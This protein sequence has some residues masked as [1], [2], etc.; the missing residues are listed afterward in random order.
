MDNS[1][2][3]YVSVDNFAVSAARVSHP[4]WDRSP[5]VIV[6]SVHPYGVVHSASGQAIREGVRKGMSLRRA[7]QKCARARFVNL[8]EIN[9]EQFM[10]PIFHLLSQLSP[11]TQRVSADE[12]F[13]DLDGCERLHGTWSAH[14]LGFLPFANPTAGTYIRDGNRPSPPHKRTLPPRN[15]RWI[16]AIGAWLRRTI[17]HRIGLPVSIGCASNTLAAQCASRFISSRGLVWIQPGA[18]A[19]FFQLLSLKD[20]PGIGSSIASKL[21]KWNIQTVNAAQRLSPHILRTTFGPKRGIKIHRL[22]HGQ[23]PHNGGSSDTPRKIS[24]ERTFWEPSN[25]YQFVE[26]VLHYLVELV[27]NRLRHQGLSTGTIGVRL[28]YQNAHAQK[29]RSSLAEHTDSNSRIFQSARHQLTARWKRNH[30]V[31][32][33]GLTASALRQTRKRQ[34]KL[35]D[36][37]NDRQRRL[38]RCVDALRDRFGFDVVHRGPSIHLEAGS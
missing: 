16:T 32:A 20:I 9:Y 29:S 11:E 34:K 14:P 3:L 27:G 24:R 17:E 25:E 7:Q 15:A 19:Q 35:F 10:N 6:T 23:P 38:D 37:D 36:S 2:I 12:G 31:R 13:A 1:I 22:L 8:D 28:C 5:L 30:R 4:T 21:H 33:V 18:E 26:A